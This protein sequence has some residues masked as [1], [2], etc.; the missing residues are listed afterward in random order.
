MAAPTLGSPAAPSAQELAIQRTILALDRTQMAWI[1]TGLSMLTFGFS[2][3]KFFQFLRQ[4]GDTRH[5]D[6]EPRHI[7]ILIM[8]AGFLAL[9]LATGQYL[10]SHKQLGSPL[11]MFRSP[12]LM[13]T[14]VLLAIQALALFWAL[15]GK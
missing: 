3:V 14:A 7:G 1:R 8:V 12:T 13:V 5:V 10:R 15:T 9:A 4:Q 11:R 2:V 6:Q